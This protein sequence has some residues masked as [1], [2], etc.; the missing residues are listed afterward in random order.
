[1]RGVFFHVPLNR[2][3]EPADGEAMCDRWWAV[4]PEKGVCFYAV[5]RGF[6]RDDEPSPQCNT[7]EHVARRLTAKLNPDHEVRQLPVVFM[8]HARKEMLRL[9][10]DAREAKP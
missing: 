9:K 2:A 6:Y 3:Q 8:T 7:S 10:R 5:L 1:M 4:H